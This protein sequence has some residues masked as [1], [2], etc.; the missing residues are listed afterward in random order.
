MRSITGFCWPGVNAA[1]LTPHT[2]RPTVRV[3]VAHSETSTQTLSRTFGVLRHQAA[4][5]MTSSGKLT[6]DLSDGT[7]Q[8]DIAHEGYPTRKSDDIGRQAFR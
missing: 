6:L 7:L 8:K 1:K 3:K 4:I 5:E 2:G